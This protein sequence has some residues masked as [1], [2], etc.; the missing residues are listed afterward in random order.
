MGFLLGFIL[1]IVAW[2]LTLPLTIIN[3]LFVE[4]KKGYFKETAKNLDAFANREF[5]AFFNASMITSDFY[6]FGNKNETI[7]E[8]LGQNYVR[9]TLSGF[10]KFWVFFIT[11]NHCLNAIN[12]PIIK[13]STF[14]WILRVFIWLASPIV[15]PLVCIYYT[16]QNIRIFILMLL[17]GLFGKLCNVYNSDLYLYIGL[18]FVVL[19]IVDLLIWI[20]RKI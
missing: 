18:S 17:S 19:S 20:K 13:E 7:S 6:K 9:E 3:F 10:G 16:P 2:L 11:P 14:T 5:R 4:N 12:Y 8:V 1:F 15:V